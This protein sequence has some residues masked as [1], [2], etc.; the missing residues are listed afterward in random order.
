[1]EH[2]KPD[3]RSLVVP[4]LSFTL[5]TATVWLAMAVPSVAAQIQSMDDCWHDLM[6]RLESRP[7]VILASLAAVF[8][9]VWVTVPTQL[10]VTIWLWRAK[11]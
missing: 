8:G 7:V 11:N 4:A 9:G 5:L 2:N 1:M 6:A 10:L 3:L